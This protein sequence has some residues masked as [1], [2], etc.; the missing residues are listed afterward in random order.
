MH[1]EHVE[2]VGHIGSARQLERGEP[3]ATFGELCAR[4][5][6]MAEQ[7]GTVLRPG[8]RALLLYPPGLEFI[9]AFL[10]CLFARVIAVPAY[11]PR[12][13]EPLLRL[14]RIARDCRAGAVLTC[15]DWSEPIAR[16]SR[17][18][19]AFAGMHVLAMNAISCEHAPA[20]RAVDV[21][22][23]SVA[24]LQYTSGSTGDP[25]GVIVTHDN[26]MD[27]SRAIRD[28]FQHTESS[29]GVGWLPL[30]HDMGLLGHVIQTLYVGMTSRI[31]SPIH[32]I[33]KPVRW[34]QAISR[35]HATTSGGPNFAY[36]MCVHRVRDEDLAALDLSSWEVAYC[37]A[38]PIRA[39]TLR[40]FAERFAVSGFR[41]KAL[42][43]CY[44]LAEATL[45]ATGAPKGQGLVC[46]ELDPK[47]LE[48]DVVRSSPEGEGLTMV[49]CGFPQPGQFVAIAAPTRDVRLAARQVGE[50]C[51]AG[52]HVSRGYWGEAPEQARARRVSFGDD[53]NRTYLRT[54]DLGYLSEAGLFVT[55]RIKDLIIVRGRNYYP[56]DL[57]WTA[58]HA[59]PALAERIGAAFAIPSEGG[60]HLVLVHEVTKSSHLDVE[61]VATA[62][63]ERIA[64]VHELSVHRVLLIRPGALPRTSSGKVR[65]AQCRADFQAGKLAVG[66]NE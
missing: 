27:N 8:D 51:I 61:Q 25:K 57:E 42:Y 12:P 31:M 41:S 38:E 24:F 40:R 28:A 29:S 35:Y 46:D 18:S 22:P 55:G 30:Q 6:F 48:N 50:I 47:E 26:I 16:I 19:A 39:K 34:L 63:R 20:G 60:E 54:G 10:G 3:A 4:A 2:H 44:G 21:D 45:F 13:S 32:F 7:I 58:R 37:G 66:R 15:A 59:H 62:I 53:P 33:Q 17:E 36:D 9:Y 65:R 5:E 64:E 56:Q 49:S 11:P 14:E 23:S 43:P 1:V 52:E